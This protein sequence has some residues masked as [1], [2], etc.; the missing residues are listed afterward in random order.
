MS[1]GYT[2]SAAVSSSAPSVRMM[3]PA[4]VLVARACVLMGKGAAAVNC[5][6]PR[7]S[8]EHQTSLVPRRVEPGWLPARR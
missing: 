3:M 4:A 7:R 8:L 6:Q 1:C 5:V 2:L